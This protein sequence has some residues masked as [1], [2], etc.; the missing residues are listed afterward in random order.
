MDAGL[1]V[2]RINFSH[3]TYDE[4]AQTIATVR[5]LARELDRPVAILGD[6]QGPRIRVGDLASPVD[7]VPGADV[8]LV[9]EDQARAGEIPVTY[10]ALSDDV[11][12]GDRV[13]MDDGLIDL[14][15]LDVS[16][17]RV[18]ARR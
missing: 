3:G 8:L 1:N 7:L 16:K 13:L 15:V 10:R 5:R 9:P 17:P 12:V 11:N 14:V 6:L 2:A 18:R 4:H